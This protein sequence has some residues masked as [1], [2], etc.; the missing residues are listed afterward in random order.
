MSPLWCVSHA[1]EVLKPFSP[2]G[3]SLEPRNKVFLTHIK[4]LTKLM[5]SKDLYLIWAAFSPSFLHSAYLEDWVLGIL[6][7]AECVCGVVSRSPQCWCCQ[8]DLE[9][10]RRL[11]EQ[12]DPPKLHSL[13]PVNVLLVHIGRFWHHNI[14]PSHFSKSFTIPT[15]FLVYTGDFFTLPAVL[16]PSFPSGIETLEKELGWRVS[17]SSGL[18]SWSESSLSFSLWAVCPDSPHCQ[19]RGATQKSRKTQFGR[20]PSG[21]VGVR[22]LFTCGT[23]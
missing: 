16:L 19:S 17:R 11:E 2:K 3:F 7:R 5:N 1:L 8:W 15:S 4:W 20:E 22:A 9:R 14:W 21:Q 18:I 12:R 13:Y 6:W 10:E 23:K